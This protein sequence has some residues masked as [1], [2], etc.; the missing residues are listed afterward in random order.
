MARL[1]PNDVKFLSVPAMAMAPEKGGRTW[2]PRWVIAV[3]T[4]TGLRLVGRAGRPV[5]VQQRDVGAAL[6]SLASRTWTVGPWV[7]GEGD[8]LPE[9][10]VGLLEKN[11][12]EAGWRLATPEEIALRGETT[13]VADYSAALDEYEAERAT[14]RLAGRGL[15]VAPASPRP[16]SPAT[17]A[18]TPPPMPEELFHYNGSGVAWA[19]QA[20]LV[21]MVAADRNGRHLVWKPGMAGW[22]PA[23]DVPEV[24]AKL[25]PVPPPFPRGAEEARVTSPAVTPAALA[26]MVQQAV[27]EA[28][29]GGLSQRSED[30]E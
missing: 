6:R 25:P 4:P 9:E 14:A 18:A 23:A 3:P 7:L 8:A 27:A 21:N 26:E 1:S 11:Y 2:S 17:T 28:L 16:A 13:D 15:V 30:D 19:T 20:M 24:A 29:H 22:T 5:W 10:A 12:G